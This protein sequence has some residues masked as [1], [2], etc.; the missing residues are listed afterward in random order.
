MALACREKFQKDLQSLEQKRDLLAVD[1]PV[2]LLRAIDE[3]GNPDVFTAELFERA[4]RSNQLSKGKAEAFAGFRC[5]LATIVVLTT[6][7]YTSLDCCPVLHTPWC[8]N[9]M[10]V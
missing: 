4:N 3:G 8:G 2:E 7:G 9:R 1:V 5:L 6:A 10:L